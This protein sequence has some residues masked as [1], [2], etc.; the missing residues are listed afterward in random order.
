M[1]SSYRTENTVSISYTVIITNWNLCYTVYFTFMYLY[2]YGKT[3]GMSHLKSI[4]RVLDYIVTV[5]LVCILYCGWFNWF[6]DVLVCVCGCF[7]NMCTCI[8]CILF[9]LYYRHRVKTRLLLLLLLWSSSSSLRIICNQLKLVSY[10]V[11]PSA[12]PSAS[13][14]TLRLPNLFLNFS[15]SYM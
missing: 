14:L 6:C 8:Y 13:S 4:Q 7:G 2:C 1:F 12:N 3:T 10:S 9:R 15:T 5:S 11:C